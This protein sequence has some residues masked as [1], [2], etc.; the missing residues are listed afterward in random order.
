MTSVAGI[1]WDSHRLVAGRQLVLG[2]VA[3]AHELGLDGHSDA[4]VLTHAVIDAL[5][6]AAAM[7]DIGQHFPDTDEQYRDADS[8]LLLRTVVATLADRGLQIAHV[9][10]TVVMER[11]KLAPHREAI[12]ASLADGLAVAPEQVNV[13]A[14]TGEG[15]GFVGRGEG[16]AALAVATVRRN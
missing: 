9:D 11:P 7:G 6:G 3:I 12:R 4:D 2:G 13:K 10:A 8:M 5:L 15:M 16:V 1:G 14:S